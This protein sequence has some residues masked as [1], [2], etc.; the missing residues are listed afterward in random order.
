MNSDPYLGDPV[1]IISDHFAVGSVKDQLAA[2]ETV[3]VHSFSANLAFWN[4]DFGGGSPEGSGFHSKS[5]KRP[6]WNEKFRGLQSKR[7]GVSFQIR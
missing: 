1:F 6:V 7:L 2:F 3:N 4:E 5:A